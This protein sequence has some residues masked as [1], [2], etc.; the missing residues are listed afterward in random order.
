ML[1]FLFIRSTCHSFFHCWWIFA[2]LHSIRFTFIFSRC[3]FLYRLNTRAQK[4]SSFSPFLSIASFLDLFTYLTV[5]S[6]FASCW[7][8]MVAFFIKNLI[9]LNLFTIKSR[10]ARTH[11]RKIWLHGQIFV[12]HTHEACDVSVSIAN[13]KCPIIGTDCGIMW[14]N[15]WHNSVCHSDKSD[16]RVL[17]HRTGSI[18]SDKSRSL[19]IMNATNDHR[20][21]ASCWLIMLQCVCFVLCFC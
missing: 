21:F 5:Y 9:C 3:L 2:I 20:C 6:C 15:D 19:L 7:L 1:R 11:P 12:S 10:S 18:S 8:T 4:F 13:S 16:E 14:Y 17:F